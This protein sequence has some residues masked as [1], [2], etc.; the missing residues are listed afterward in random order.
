MNEG[1]TVRWY[2]TALGNEVDMHTLHWH[3]NSLEFQFTRTDVIAM[4][5]ASMYV[6]D[7]TANNPG[8]CKLIFSIKNCKTD[9]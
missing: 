5:P 4:L 9:K 6:A 2:A 7:M 3:A 8:T 1:E